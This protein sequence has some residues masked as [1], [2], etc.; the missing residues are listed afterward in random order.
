M[1][2]LHRRIH[3]TVVHFSERSRHSVSHIATPGYPKIRCAQRVAQG[4]PIAS[5]QDLDTFLEMCQRPI[6]LRDLAQRRRLPRFLLPL[7]MPMRKCATPEQ[8][9]LCLFP[10]K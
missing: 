5:A 9:P 2:E 10:L 7:Q 3:Y 4:E 6:S 1:G 8:A